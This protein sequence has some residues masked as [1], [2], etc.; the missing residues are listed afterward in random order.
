M[1]LQ[2]LNDIAAG[3]RRN[4]AL[5]AGI[6]RQNAGRV[7]SYLRLM[8]SPFLRTGFFA[9]CLLCA[10][11]FLH[12]F[13]AFGQTNYYNPNGTEYAIVGNLPGDQVYPDVAVNPSG[14]VVVWQDNVT[15][16]GGWGISARQLDGTL[17]GSLGTFS[18]NTTNVT[19]NQQN[20]RVALL[21]GGGS[22]FVW[23][24]GPTGFQHIYA[25]FRNSTNV[26]MTN[27]FLVNTPT[28]CY[29]ANPAV[30]VLNNSNVVV[31]WSSFDEASSNSMQDVYGQ[32]LSPGGK[33]IG[34]EFIINQYTNFNQ[35]SPAVAALTGGGFVVTWISEQERYSGPSFTN[36]S[37]S[38]ITVSASSLPNPSVDVYARLYNASGTAQ[39]NEF[40]VNADNNPCANAAVSGA[41]DGSFLVVWAE[42]DVVNLSN[43]FD[44]YGRVFTNGT[45]TSG[46]SNFL[47]NT[48]QYGDQYYPRIAALGLDYL[49]TW[50]SLA[51]DGSREGVYGQYVHNNGSLTG[52]QF[53]VNT[54]TQGSQMQQAVASDGSTQFL[55]VWTSFSGLADGF[56]LYAQRYINADAVLVAMP[57]PFVWE[58]FVLSNKVYQP[59]LVVSWAPLLGLSVSNYEVYVDGATL[60]AAM[61]TSNQWNMTA[62]NGLTT[63]STHSFQVD[64]V[65]N[66]G[67]RSP[68][69]PSSSGT[70][71]SGLSWGGIPY[72]WM[73]AYFG[74]YSNGHYTTTF[75]PSASLSLAPGLTLYQVFLSGGDPLDPT[76]WLNVRFAKTS[77]GMFIIWNTQPGAT[78]QVQTTTNFI[79]WSSLGSPRFAAGTSDSINVGSGPVSFYRVLLMR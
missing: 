10:V 54:T 43:G 68:I 26:F 41:S 67:R 46:A 28:N 37:S 57:A 25:R 74:G 61:V 27:E 70:T 38:F 51:E 44:I 49:V 20:P 24:G 40:P 17:S 78:Y 6:F 69:S 3:V 5:E 4:S 15:V 9:A 60:P 52:S 23:Q 45:S 59:T 7:L 50:T 79:T 8:I 42:R 76:T 18:V 48:Y 75:W 11:V 64:Y 21:K 2:S 72:E 47:V 35:R 73:A 63:N 62:A 33:K 32:I 19:G 31:V 56:D 30:T 34:G 14:G 58:P 39:G 77:M 22:V 1:N 16:E 12:G 36:S 65:M 13:N 71:W 66:D 29:Q 53:L 55:A